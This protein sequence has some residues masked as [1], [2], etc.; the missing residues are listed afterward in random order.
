LHLNVVSAVPKSLNSGKADVNYF[1]VSDSKLLN[2]WTTSFLTEL[3]L[4]F[5]TCC[6]I[7]SLTK[8]LLL[9]SVRWITS[10][11]HF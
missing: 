3:V 7:S 5:L 8:V 4:N 9:I 11:V 10:G 1:K 2:K 6:C